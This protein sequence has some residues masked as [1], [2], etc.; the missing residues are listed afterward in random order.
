MECDEAKDPG[1]GPRP[2]AL[3][4]ELWLKI[5]EDLGEN[6]SLYP[7]AMTCR[8]FRHI[9][10][11]LAKLDGTKGRL[12]TNFKRMLRA[13]EFS[14]PSPSFLKWCHQN[15]GEVGVGLRGKLNTNLAFL[16]AALGSLET[17]MWLRGEGFDPL[18]AET[19][20]FAAVGGHMNVVSWLASEK[21]PWGEETCASAAEG[22]HLSVLKFLRS[23]GC[24]WNQWTCSNAAKEGHLEVLRWARNPEDGERCPWS[25]LASAEASSQGHR[26]RSGGF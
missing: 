17:L 1:S 26:Q 9:Q 13:R 14:P 25:D 19:F 10:K 12:R 20:Q 21:C 16:G 5:A 4:S 2:G 6:S 15:K 22:G 23:K 7:F 18:S 8:F 3:P 24:P 11:E